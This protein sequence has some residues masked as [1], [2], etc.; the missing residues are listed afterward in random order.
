MPDP[1]LEDIRARLSAAK[2]ATAPAEG[3]RKEDA[4]NQ[5]Q[6]LRAGVELIAAILASGAVGFGIDHIFDTRPFGFIIMLFLGIFTGFYNVWRVMNNLS[7]SSGFQQLHNGPKNANT[8]PND[9][10]R[11]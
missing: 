10:D 8:A 7:I 6:G 1:N 9:V 11:P 5:N 4:Q 2:H 3:Q